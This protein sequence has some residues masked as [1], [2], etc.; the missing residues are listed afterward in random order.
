MSEQMKVKVT[1]AALNIREAPGGEILRE[2]PGN[3]V[4][5]VLDWDS[6]EVWAKVQFENTQGY[7]MKDYL[8]P[9]TEDEIND[10]ALE[11]KQKRNE[12]KEKQESGMFA[13]I[14]EKI[15]SVTVF[16]CV[17][18]II[19]SVLLGV[20]LMMG[21]AVLP[22]LLTAVLGAIG[23]YLGSMVMYGLGEL[24]TESKRQRA[25]QEEILKALRSK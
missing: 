14:G 12:E 20:I 21:G 4:L 3:A 18:G 7:A 6:S 9:V 8:Q 17:V 19:V 16:F 2:A 13:N 15:K 5:T 24:I 25:V 11:E 10:L 23:S 22:G 1:A